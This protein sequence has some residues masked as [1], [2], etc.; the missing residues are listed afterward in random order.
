MDRVPKKYFLTKGSGT[1]QTPLLSFEAALKDADIAAYNLV[2][3]SSIIPPNC[4]EINIKKGK[5]YLSRGEIVYTVLSEHITNQSAKSISCALGIARPLDN[6]LHGYV[7]EHSDEDKP[8]ETIGK[9]AEQCAISM[10]ANASGLNIQNIE[11]VHNNKDI[12]KIL[13]QSKYISIEEQANTDT[14][15]LTVIAALIFIL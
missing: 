3:V 9:F 5:K 2:K 12:Q 13:S 11:R 10:V 4:Q 1:G 15:F 14:N 7:Y 8:E 6:S